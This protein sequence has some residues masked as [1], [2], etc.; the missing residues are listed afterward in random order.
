MRPGRLRV[1]PL[2]SPIATQPR[3]RGIASIANEVYVWTLPELA[4]DPGAEPIH[5]AVP[6]LTL[7]VDDEIYALK[8]TADG[9][10]LVTVDRQTS[11]VTW[12]ATAPKKETVATDME[13]FASTISPDATKVAFSQFSSANPR[14]I[15]W[16]LA[17]KHEVL[18]L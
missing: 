7:R 12:D 8:F 2:A 1:A 9:R 16:D 3:P 14:S 10:Q 17:A 4:T 13:T 11:I 5:I 15:L 18:R 6:D